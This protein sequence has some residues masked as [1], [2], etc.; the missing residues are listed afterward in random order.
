MANHA[1]CSICKSDS[2]EILTSVPVGQ[3]SIAVC[4]KCEKQ[5]KGAGKK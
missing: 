5:L 1:G 4:D 3:N 2:Q